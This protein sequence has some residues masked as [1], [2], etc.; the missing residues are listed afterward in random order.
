MDELGR[1]LAFIRAVRRGCAERIVPF[2][3]GAAFFNDTLPRVYD[4]NFLQVDLEAT[5]SDLAAEA[6]RIQAGLGHR[7]LRIDDEALAAGLEPDFRELGWTVERHLVMPHRG[8]VP[9]TEP[10]GVVEVDRETLEP[11]WAEGI[12]SEPFGK[13][14]DVVRQLVDHKRVVAKA[15]RTRYFA[16]MVDGAPVSYCELYSDEETAQIEAVMT[17]EPYRGRGLAKAVVTKALAEANAAGHSL[18]FLIADADDWPHEL[19]S[20]LG[21]EPV[22]LKH[23]LLRELT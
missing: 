2:P 16:A 19:Y 12:R 9:E 11:V 7:K 23:E 8:A 21:F 14:D 6:G 17:L 10:A 5:A 22:G 18:V 4:L 15:I 3:F 13:D 20:K 1:A